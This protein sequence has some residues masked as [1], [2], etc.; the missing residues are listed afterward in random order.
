MII[1][2]TKHRRKL[3][4]MTTFLLFILVSGLARPAGFANVSAEAGTIIPARDSNLIWREF[5]GLWKRRQLN[6]QEPKAGAAA[7]AVDTNEVIMVNNVW[8][9]VPLTQVIRDISMETGAIIA[10]CPHVPDPL[11]SLDAGSGKPLQECLQELVAG[12]GLF[13]YPRNKRF[14]L[15]SC[16]A[17]TCPSF[18]EIASSKRLCLKYITAKHLQSSLPRS[19]Q[20]YISSGERP[21]E[22]LIYAV[23]EIMKH[24]M[25]IVQ[26]LDIPRQQVVLEV[27]VVE[28]WEEASKEFGLDWEYQDQDISLGISHGLGVFT[29]IAKYTSVPASEFTNL[30]F[31]IKMLV[32]KNKASIRSR[33]RVATL[34][35]QK[36]AIDIS[37]D[38][39]YT[40]VTDIGYYGGALRT[41]LQVIKSGV[42]LEIIPHI[43]D[44]GNITV[45]VL[46]EVSDV[47]TRQN[48]TN[49][50][51]GVDLPVIRRRKANTCV[52]VKQGDAIVIG[53]LI[54][55][56]EHND[57]K[58]VP[59]LGDIPLVGG[60]FRWTK[61]NTI[62]KEVI[63]FITPRLMKEGI[64]PFSDRHNSL[65]VD[66]ELES[67]RRESP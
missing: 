31:T 1:L 30:L 18:L 33:P 16:G 66:K 63:I 64:S 15:I 44:N 52:R 49:N 7:E 23:P 14:Y 34:N 53:G 26:K 27:L 21:T 55:T 2:A 46:T 43:G 51:N 48:T 35:G 50:D 6:R 11:I 41:Q 9:D 54:E 62:E 42:L 20:Q 47:A 12:R 36:A 13:I 8:G 57:V 5:Q 22:V 60:L 24:I 17:T 29:G 65:D 37:L 40:I 67:L 28:L 56:Q 61:S 4:G 19:L 3:R 10:C 39:Y 45:D 32:G 59:I 38:E 58:K 25:E